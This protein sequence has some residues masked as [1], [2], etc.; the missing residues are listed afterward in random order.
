MKNISVFNV[1]P[2]VN[3]TN[4]TYGTEK[5]HF[6]SWS[7]RA[8]IYSSIIFTVLGCPANMLSFLVFMRSILRLSPTGTYLMT[9]SWV[10]SLV[11]ILEVLTRTNV[12]ATSTTSCKVT[13]YLRYSFKLLEAFLV[14]SLCISRTVCLIYPFSSHKCF[15]RST[16]ALCIVLQTV[17]AFLMCIYAL[18]SIIKY[19]NTCNTDYRKPNKDIYLIA[20]TVISVIIG[21]FFTSLIVI[22][23]AIF[24][25]KT[26][27][28]F[29]LHFREN[30]ETIRHEHKQRQ[31]KNLDKQI[32]RMTAAVAVTFTCFRLP[33]SVLYIVFCIKHYIYLHPYD[34]SQ[35]NLSAAIDVAAVFSMLNY[36]TNF[37]IYVTF[38]KAFRFRCWKLLTCKKENKNNCRRFSSSKRTEMTRFIS[39]QWK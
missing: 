12:V 9:I 2:G 7:H 36:C 28:N 19:G 10:D 24:L 38:W 31:D 35:K 33:Y 23:L 37:L 22:F 8:R 39:S 21:E 16:A 27:E 17:A 20:D 15:K 3:Y 32:T 29:R 18:L 26:L 25:M 13:Y 6:E 14:V 11:L 5:D 4:V 34:Q 1:S 30:S